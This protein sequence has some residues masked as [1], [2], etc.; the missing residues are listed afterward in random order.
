V[1]AAGVMGQA[2]P[3]WLLV[4]EL[5]AWAYSAALVASGVANGLVNPSIHT[6]LTLRIPARLRPGAL[7]AMAAVFT[8]IQ[9]LGVFLAGPV[10]D[11]YGVEPVLVALAVIQTVCMAAIAL[12]ALR[13]RGALDR[14]ESETIVSETDA[15]EMSLSDAAR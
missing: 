12:T 13:E 3:L 1:T 2:L 8:L 10:L 9:P 5:P 7:A 14:S 4:F 11:S 6:I 15:L